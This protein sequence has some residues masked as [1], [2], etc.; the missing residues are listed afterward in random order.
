[1]PALINPTQWNTVQNALKGQLGEDVYNS[2]IKP[3]RL[4]SPIEARTGAP[5]EDNAITLAVPTQFMQTWINDN[6]GAAIEK[7][8]GETLQKDISVKYVIRP[9]LADMLGAENI[10]GGIHHNVD[11]TKKAAP[12]HQQT[13]PS[14]VQLDPRYTFDTYVTGKSNDLAVAA[15]QRIAES[16]TPIYNPFF[17]HGGVGLGKTHLMHAIGHRMQLLFPEKKVLYLSAEH[18]LQRFIKAMREK[19]TLS[20]KDAMR[21]VDVLMID[22]IQFIAGKNSTQEEFFHTFNT[23]VAMGKQ[24]ILTADRS[25]P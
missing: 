13:R 1:M 6:Y 18:F 15:A 9:A 2:W 10:A 22:D 17:L 12:T 14:A 4:D 21:A 16:E 3:L 7:S 23:L 5:G 25:P 19:D 20:F 11:A 24:V 8:L